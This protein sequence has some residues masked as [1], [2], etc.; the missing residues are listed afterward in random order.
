MSII[1]FIV[2]IGSLFL[3][4]KMWK[5]S[6]WFSLLCFSP[7]FL[8]IAFI[9]Y[10]SYHFSYKTT[11]DSLQVHV[12]K[13][14]NHFVLNGIWKDRLDKFRYPIDFIVFYIPKNEEMQGVKDIQLTELRTEEGDYLLEEVQEYLN[15]EHDSQWKPQ[16]FKMNTLKE[17]QYTFSL[18]QNVN[19]GEVDVL[20]I[21]VRAEPMDQWEY[22]YKKINLSS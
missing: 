9:S 11:L 21:H 2:F 1:V 3:G 13:E 15:Q 5:K 8:I 20:Y 19:P 18:P 17:F 14:N 10:Y 22:W 6:R 12:E 4:I 16:I 7:I